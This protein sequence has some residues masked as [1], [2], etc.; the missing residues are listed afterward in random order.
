MP[1]RQNILLFLLVLSVPMLFV[2]SLFVGSVS[3]PFD[4]V[5]GALCGD[6]DVKE[7]WR[8]IVIESR[9]PQSL[10]AMLCGMSLAVCGLL[11]QTVFRNPLAEPSI[12]GMS[13]GAGVGVAC[14][15]MLMGG[16]L[17]ASLF[18]IGGFVAI[19]FAAF[20]GAM[21][22]TLLLLGMSLLVRSNSMLLIAGI[23]I[24][25]LTSSF[26]TLSYYVATEEGVRLYTLWGM[27]TFAGVAMKH[28]PAFA[29]MLLVPL[30]AAFSFV[31][32]LNALSLGDGYAKSLG[33]N[34]RRTRALL[35]VIVGLL[36]AVTTAFCG[37]VA[38]IGLAVPH[39]VRLLFGVS[40]HRML[41]PL[42]GVMGAVVAL[43]CHVCCMMP[44]GGSQLPINAVTPL[45]GAPVVIYV[46][47]KQKQ[48]HT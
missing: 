28:I 25:Y 18:T 27:G 41:L 5:L 4:D 48:I 44:S 34:V 23:M 42:S 40:N 8:Y 30:A 1:Q 22:V 13:G 2:L 12:L 17:S 32:P 26:I 21:I 46:I 7:T 35:L 47:L 43:L 10:T 45:I 11:L 38:F 19:V 6:E 9:L 3:I 16:S 31:K 24:G 39:L 37:P 29:F 15:L 20:A 33:V 14:V 36:T